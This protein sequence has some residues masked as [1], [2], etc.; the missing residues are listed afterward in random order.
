MKNVT[1]AKSDASWWEKPVIPPSLDV[2]EMD[3]EIDKVSQLNDRLLSDR[4]ELAEP[5][6]G[7]L[8][9]TKNFLGTACHAL[10]P[11]TKVILAAASQG[12]SLVKI[13][14][15][16]NEINDPGPGLK[17]IWDSFQ[18]AVQTDRSNTLG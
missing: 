9:A 7:I 11:A 10:S 1:D 17:S 5:Q 12:S 6:R 16:S 8:P 15:K 14:L 2:K 18:H 4:R 3:S 13:S